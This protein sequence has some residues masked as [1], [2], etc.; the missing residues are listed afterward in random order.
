MSVQDDLW[1]AA[2]QAAGV[3]EGFKVEVVGGQLIMSPQSNVQSWTIADIQVV[4]RAAGLKKSRL[5]SDVLVRFG[6]EPPRAPDVAI[7]EDGAT[8]PYK[9]DDLLAAIEIVSA[10]DDQH[11]YTTKLRQY[12]RFEV[13]IY[14][15]V[16]PFRATCTLLTRPS[17]EEYATRE[18][19]KYGETVTLR[20]AD[21]ITVNIPTDEFERRD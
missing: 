9:H 7:L 10:K 14:L 15:I 19:F 18:Q 13:P 5:V 11:D 16:D 4:A 1:R 8:A 17:G 2:E 21:G 12:A 20:L 6:E 3:F